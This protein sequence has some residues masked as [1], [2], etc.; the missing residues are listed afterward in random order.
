MELKEF[1]NR[2][3]T[4]I[5]EGVATGAIAAKKVGA[6]VNPR[7]VA[8]G[9]ELDHAESVAIE[10]HRGTVSY[11]YNAD[12]RAIGGCPRQKHKITLIRFH[13]INVL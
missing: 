10:I 11:G 9:G 1:V 3:L 5:A 4:E 12:K 13:Q 2:T 7:D 6:V 8:L